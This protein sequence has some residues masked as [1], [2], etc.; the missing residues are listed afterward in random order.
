MTP[1]QQ[2][3]LIEVL[4]WICSAVIITSIIFIILDN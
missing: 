4:A 3:I 1:K 2:R